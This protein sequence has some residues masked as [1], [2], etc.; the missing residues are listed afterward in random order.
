[1]AHKGN[2]IP[3]RETKKQ[4]DEERRWEIEEAIRTL[5]K[6]EMLKKNKKLMK[7][8]EKAMKDGLSLVQAATHNS[9]HKSGG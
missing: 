3:A 5:T 8:V 2:A 9:K 7:D 6:A 4:M 1:M